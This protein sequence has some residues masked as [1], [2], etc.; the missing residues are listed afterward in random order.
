MALT[1]DRNTLE[2]DGIGY[3]YPIAAATE[4]F[5]G[6]LTVLDASGN[7][8]P[9]TAA[10]GK[11]AVGRSEEYVNNTGGAGA[12]NLE[13]KAGI[14]RWKNSAGD[15]VTKANIGDHVY[16]EDDE[17]VCATATGKSPAGVMVDFETAGVWV[18]TKPPVSMITGLLAANN[19]SD[20]GSVATSRSNLA[21]DTGD[22]PTFAAAT[23]TGDVTVGG[24]LPVTG[25]GTIGGSLIVTGE[26]SGLEPTTVKAAAYTV[27]APDDGGEV[28]QDLTDNAII[29]LPNCAAGNKGLKVTI[30][31]TAAAAAAKLSI[32]PDASDKIVGQ[33]QAVAS[34]GVAN[35]D[36]INT[37]ATQLPGDYTKL[38]SDGVDTWWI[39]GGVGVWVSEV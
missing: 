4:N 17:T 32:N 31:N 37:K 34:G 13:V 9:G 2:R 11:I 30:Q 38:M 5:M 29:T 1:A 18:E 23:T 12:K 36:W 6:A 8:E 7:A 14:F 3:N 35:K 28:I 15:P 27:V 24:D 39:I 19:L 16:V 33:V 21:L 20:V 10:T 25:N 22:S 26:M